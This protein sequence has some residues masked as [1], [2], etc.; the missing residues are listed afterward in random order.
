[1]AWSRL[2][3]LWRNLRH[4]AA[5]DRDLDAELN[6]TLEL[7]ID[8]KVA[9]G[10]EPREA[11]RRALIE[12]GGIEPVKDRVRDVRMGVF[13]ETLLQD[14]HYALRHF[15]RA[16]AFATSAVVT[17][18]IGIGANA[19]MISIVNALVFKRLPVPDPDGLVSLTTIDDRGNERYLPF[20]AVDPFLDN[21]P[22]KVLCGY[23]GGGVHTVE[24]GGVATVALSAFV[25]GKCFDTFGVRPFIGRPIVDADAP[26]AGPGNKVAVISH[27][28]WTR[29]FGSDPAVVG[30]TFRVETIELTVVGV[31]PEGFGGLHIDTAVDFYAAPDTV[32]PAP[33]E[34][35]PVATQLVGRLRE[36]V[37]MQQASAQLAA[38][39]PQVRAAT[40]GDASKAFEGAALYGNTT[41]LQSMGTGISSTLRRRYGSS[42]RMM[43]GLTALL[44]VL[45]CVNVGGLLLTRLSG[46]SNELAM[47]LALGGSR[48][49]VAQQMIVEGL[50]LSVAGTV[51]ALPVA[52]ALIGAIAS[53]LP[54]N[55]IARTI[56]LTPDSTILGLMTAIGLVA[57]LLITALPVWLAVRRQQASPLAWDRTIAPATNW[58]ARGMLVAQVAVSVVIVV[59]A[60]LLVRSLYR[61]QRVD[62]GVKTANVID[63]NL[64]ALPGGRFATTANRSQD[65]LPYYTGMLEKIAALP[66]VQSVGMSQVFPRQTLPPG[67]AVSI[68]GEPDRNILALA[69]TISPG[70]FETIGA[71]LVT[72]R[73]F[74]WAD[75]APTSRVCIVTE[76]LARQ[77]HPDGDVLQRH[78]RFGTIRDRQDMTIIGVVANV[79]LGNL[80]HEHPPIAFVPPQS[81]G[82]NFAAPNILIATSRSMTSTAAAVRA[83]LAEGGREYAREITTVDELFARA[84]ASERMTAALGA[85][86]GA[87]AILLAIIGIH[88]VLAYSVARRTREIGVRVAIGANPGMVARSVMR[89]AATLTAIGLMAGL[90]LALVTSRALRSLLYGVSETDA[91][92]FAS[93]A[94]FFLVVGGIA[95]VLPARRA[96]NV[97]PVIALRGD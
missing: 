69:D 13:L 37:S 1:M 51:L 38:M 9:A 46:R 72:G 10:L 58:W 74:T 4:G 45:M 92:T 32:F 70:F 88:G 95:G 55:R 30:K 64:L 83:I 40:T 33:K 48:S 78:L 6:A 14:F 24:A 97:D 93:V 2:R 94:V 76:S 21:G 23:N 57:G 71:P 66:G 54:Q 90:P 68:V 7:L 49:R 39:W 89:D 82:V 77:L 18:A 8:E 35:R 81:N 67:T 56:E 84:P 11:R 17:L 79:N 96:A 87:L 5:V 41:Q 34:R 62:T 36:G 20:A 47:R 3:S 80:R 85:M 44:L 31:M 42:F 50:A 28:F 53:F 25:S 19:A 73:F 27:R 59:G 43:A 16:P 60:S 63:V 12:M 29:L 75:S 26:W 65:I 52:F 22:F 86:M 91:M 15:R 61:I